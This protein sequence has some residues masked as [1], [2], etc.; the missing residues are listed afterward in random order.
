MKAPTGLDAKDGKTL[1]TIIGTGKVTLTTLFTDMTKA[2]ATLTHTYGKSTE[3]TGKT[4]S[5]GKALEGQKDE[6]EIKDNKYVYKGT[7]TEVVVAA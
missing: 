1:T 2:P 5:N 7:T 4:G 6:I 3:R